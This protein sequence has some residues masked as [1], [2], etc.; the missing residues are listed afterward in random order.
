MGEFATSCSNA[1]QFHALVMGQIGFE[2]MLMTRGRRIWIRQHDVLYD[3][4]SPDGDEGLYNQ[5]CV[6]ITT[7][8][9]GTEVKW[10]VNSPCITSLFRAISFLPSTK[11]PYIMRFFASGWFEEIFED[12]HAAVRRIEAIIARGDRHFLSRVFIEQAEPSMP[13]LPDVLKEALNNQ[14]ILDEF[15]VDCSFDEVTRTVN[16]ERV[17]PMSAIGRVWGTAT[18]S[19]P[20]KTIGTYGETVN[21]TYEDVLNTGKPRYDQI[22]ASLR[23]PDNALHWVPYHRIVFPKPRLRGHLGVAVL[24]QISKV[25]IQVL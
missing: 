22:L 4:Q 16:V 18:T 10:H 17:G 19:Y 13:S 12:H 21:A 7:G 1:V 6:R 15:S 9:M 3:A 11:P 20:C 25:D 2:P 24:S 8:A 14:N 5:G 23:L